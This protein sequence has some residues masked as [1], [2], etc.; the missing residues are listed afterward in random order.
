MRI[1]ESF[2]VVVHTHAKPHTPLHNVIST[3]ISHFIVLYFIVLH[4]C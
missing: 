3:D 4:G 1:A 2:L